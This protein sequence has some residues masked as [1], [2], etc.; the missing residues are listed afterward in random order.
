MRF[1]PRDLE[2]TSLCASALGRCTYPFAAVAPDVVIPV[3]VADLSRY[4]REQAAWVRGTTGGYGGH[5]HGPDIEPDLP[6]FGHVDLVSADGEHGHGIVVRHRVLGLYWLPTPAYPAGR[7]SVERSA[8]LALQEEVLLCEVAHGIDYTV[9]TDQ[10]RQ[11]ILKAYHG[12]LS[13]EDV[14][15]VSDWFEE[16][17]ELDYRDWVGE[18]FM[19]GLVLAYSDIQPSFDFFTH[20]TTPDVV[21]AIRETL[22]PA[23]PRDPLVGFPRRRVYHK[24]SCVVVRIRPGRAVPL[25]PG[26]VA[27]RRACRVCRPPAV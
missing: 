17:G 24:P 23:P 22:T 6:T 9:M 25:E 10:Q 2:A 4:V 11:T 15:H 8:P 1:A 7:I 14:G 12:G 3:E 21:A 13:P 16:Q 18:S 26:Q 27:M 5:G 19:L 20:K